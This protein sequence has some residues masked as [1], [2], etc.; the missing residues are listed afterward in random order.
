MHTDERG[1]FC[2][3]ITIPNHTPLMPRVLQVSRCLKRDHTRP[4]LEYEFTARD[5]VLRLSFRHRADAAAF[6][7]YFNTKFVTRLQLIESV[8]GVLSTA[9][10]RSGDI[11][12]PQQATRP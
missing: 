1:L 8:K 5:T 4:K 11:R 9:V 7:K 3:T 2:V 12:R 10:S 6:A